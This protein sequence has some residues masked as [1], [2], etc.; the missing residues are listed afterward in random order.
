[1]E[2]SDL[3]YSHSCLRVLVRVPVPLTRVSLGAVVIE[4]ATGFPP[5]H[6]LAPVPALFK[7]PSSSAPYLYPYLSCIYPYL[8]LS[9]RALSFSLSL[10]SMP[11]HA[12]ADRLSGHCARHATSS[13]AGREGLPLPLL[14][15]RRQE[16]RERITGANCASLA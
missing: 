13:F 6:D 11:P 2:V 4:M 10:S 14:P 9:L 12:Y 5:F 3:L 15:T 1:M 7:V 8:C 16:A